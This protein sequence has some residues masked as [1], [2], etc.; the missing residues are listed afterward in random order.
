MW[1]FRAAKGFGLPSGTSYQIIVEVFNLLGT[2]NTF[3]DPRTNA[4][5]GQTNFRE[6]N[7]TLGPRIVQLD[8]RVE[9]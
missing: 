5:W 2:K 9:F 8:M 7:R 1:D 3:S 4:I 6:R